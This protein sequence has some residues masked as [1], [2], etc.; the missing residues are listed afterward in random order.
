ML[1]KALAIFILQLIYVPLL[2]LRT[3]LVVKG[4]KNKAVLW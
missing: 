3:A 1:V 4:E 2:T